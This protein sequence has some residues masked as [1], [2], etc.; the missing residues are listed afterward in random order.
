M[1]L[2]ADNSSMWNMGNL[3]GAL[4]FLVIVVLGIVV[5]R[6]VAGGKSKIEDNE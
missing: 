4:F 1:F 3:M 2:Q 6:M 5:W